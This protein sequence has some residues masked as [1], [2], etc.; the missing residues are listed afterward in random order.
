MLMFLN[1][2]NTAF[3]YIFLLNLFGYRIFKNAGNLTHPVIA[4]LD[5]PLFAYGV[6]RVKRMKFVVLRK[7]KRP[8]L[9][10]IKV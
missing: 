7:F 6:K 3:S 10:L 8:S 4:T 2:C 5:R 1:T 9:E